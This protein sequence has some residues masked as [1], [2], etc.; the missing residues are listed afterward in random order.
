[1]FGDSLE[2]PVPPHGTLHLAG[3]V[4]ESNARQH[5]HH[6]LVVYEV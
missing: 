5:I 4:F 3:I 1:M 2:R 6:H